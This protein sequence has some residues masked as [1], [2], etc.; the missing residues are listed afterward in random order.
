AGKSW[1][2]FATKQV[3]T[4]SFNVGANVLVIDGKEVPDTTFVE[5]V[6]FSPD[7]KHYAAVCRNTY[8]TNPWVIVVDGKASVFPRIDPQDPYWTPDSSTLVYTAGTAEGSVIV[9]NE[10]VYRYDGSF[11]G[12]VLPEEGNKFAWRAA[13]HG[14]RQYSVV[15]DAKN[16]IPPGVYPT[17][18]VTLS[19]DGSRHAYLVGPV[20]RGETTGLVVDG[21]LQTGFRPATF[22]RSLHDN[23][24]EVAHVAF[25]PDNQ[26]AA[27][28][29]AQA[30]PV[31][32][33][34]IDGTTVYTGPGA[35]SHLKFSPDSN[36]LYWV[37][38]N[39]ANTTTVYVDGQPAVTANGHVFRTARSLLALARDGTG[40][41]FAAD[42]AVVKRYKITPDAGTNVATLLEKGSMVAAVAPAKPAPAAVSA[43]SAP[44]TG[45]ST[46]A[47]LP[48]SSAAPAAVVQSPAAA[49]AVAALTWSDL[50]RRIET[51]P[52]VCTVVREFKFQGGQTIRAGTPVMVLEV[53]PNELVVGTV[54]G[55]TNFGVKPQETD[56]VDVANKLWA[57]LTP[58]QRELTYATVL[59]RQELWPYRLKLVLPFTL[60]GRT[61]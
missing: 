61:T 14:R 3:S 27:Y 36:H 50:V 30:A 6:S 5:K 46:A 33:I 60:D 4:G 32:S 54:D 38:I 52:P 26:R 10:D 22:L 2:A 21:R 40:Y 41:F 42:G 18:G 31:K 9:V 15:F 48:A 44:A 51:R 47:P 16:T 35:L 13:D 57:Q 17:S 45:A 12:I 28:V 53:K 29:A 39:N 49:G 34:L 59:R 7:G 20:G 24:S 19:R 37:T 23:L 11:G 43:P 8:G 58:A 25:S 1:A 56:I 55:A